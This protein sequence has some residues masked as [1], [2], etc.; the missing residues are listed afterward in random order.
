MVHAGEIFRYFF[1]L[2]AGVCAGVAIVALPT[3]YIYMRLRM[4]I[5]RG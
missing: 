4:R 5:M 1:G 2:A 3:W